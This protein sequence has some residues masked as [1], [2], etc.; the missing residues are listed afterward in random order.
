MTHTRVAI[1]AAQPN[2]ERCPW[3][4]FDAKTVLKD[5]AMELGAAGK[6]GPKVTY[7]NGTVVPC[8]GHTIGSFLSSDRAVILPVIRRQYGR[9][10]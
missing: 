10:G 8:C 7:G 3:F 5:R 1:S 4:F 2:V 9:D 6:P